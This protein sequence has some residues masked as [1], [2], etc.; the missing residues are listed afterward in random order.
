M[1]SE[2]KGP[3]LTKSTESLEY[4]SSPRTAC[5]VCGLFLKSIR[6]GQRATVQAGERMT[7]AVLSP[8]DAGVERW[9][10]WK[11][12]HGGQGLVSSTHLGTPFHFLLPSL[13]RVRGS[14]HGPV[15]PSWESSQAAL[16]YWAG[17]CWAGLG[18]FLSLD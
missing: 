4:F 5:D 3:A 12:C 9:G 8:G 16:P 11:V 2:S 18:S 15:G 6:L 7:Q 14:L 1:E 17:S 13:H 10:R